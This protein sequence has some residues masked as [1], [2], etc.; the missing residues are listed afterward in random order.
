MALA[1]SISAASQHA[2][3]DTTLRDPDL[4]ADLLKNGNPTNR[5]ALARTEKAHLPNEASHLAEL[6]AGE[7]ENDVKNAVMRWG[8]ILAG[9]TSAGDGY[10]AGLHS[11]RRCFPVGQCSHFA[12]RIDRPAKADRF[13]AGRVR[14]DYGDRGALGAGGNVA[15]GGLATRPQS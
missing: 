6:L 7:P 12:F 11:A 14:S 3:G 10:A 9:L 1:V 5:A 4:A 2:Q 8:T 15:D 13:R